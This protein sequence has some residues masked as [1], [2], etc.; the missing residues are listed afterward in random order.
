M[1]S[2]SQFDCSPA[3]TVAK[4]YIR[5]DFSTKVVF[6]IAVCYS[7]TIVH[8]GIPGSRFWGKV[9]SMVDRRDNNEL[10]WKRVM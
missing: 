9:T 6:P 3:I 4:T 7:R 5:Q 1:P 10:V 2:S 8:L